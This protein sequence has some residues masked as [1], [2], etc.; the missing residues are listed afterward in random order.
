MLDYIV[1]IKVYISPV[2]LK[3]TDGEVE[4]YCPHFPTVE[5]RASFLHKEVIVLLR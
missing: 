3:P 2:D 5:N 1:S 4:D